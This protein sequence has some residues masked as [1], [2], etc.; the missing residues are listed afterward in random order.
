M[1][2]PE[3]VRSER[4]PDAAEIDRIADEL[5]P[6]LIAHFNA[7]GLGELE[8]RRGEWR[9][10]L[11]APD[12][13]ITGGSEAAGVA[14][15]AAGRKAARS[16][17]GLAAAASPRPISGNGQSADPAPTAAAGTGDGA[18]NRVPADRSVTASPGVGYFT[19]R[20][21][22]A[23]G[24]AVRGG[25]VLGHVDVLGVRVEVIAPVDGIVARLLADAGE[26]VEYGQELVR[27]DRIT[28][29]P[30]VRES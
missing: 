19:A 1:A 9:V 25:D 14:T 24:T 17:G 29:S 22:L 30:T 26:A 12:G 27:L 2:R 23:P 8:I 10:R 28:P 7:S 4:L 6:A 13:G 20:D 3:R 16:T 21:G 11:R 18:A 15:T 5:L